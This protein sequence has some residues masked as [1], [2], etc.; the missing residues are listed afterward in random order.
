MVILARPALPIKLI[1][2]ILVISTVVFWFGKFISKAEGIT[3]NRK[4]SALLLKLK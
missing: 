3:G 4:L 1:S 2:P